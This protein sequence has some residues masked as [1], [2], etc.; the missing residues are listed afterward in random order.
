MNDHQHHERRK[1]G[2]KLGWATALT[3]LFFGGELGV[4]IYANSLALIGDA[5]HNVT[6]A[7]ALT[8]AMLVLRLERRPATHGKSFGYTRA[9]V[10]AA[11]VNAAMLLGIT[12]FLLIEA[13]DRFNNPQPV[14]SFWMLTAAGIALVLN[15]SMTLWLRQESKRD[16]NIRGAV[17]HLTADS[18]AS[19]GVIIGALLIRATG[20][21]VYDPAVSVV[22]GGLILL[23]SYGILRETVNL[24][25]E[26]TPSGIDPQAVTRD[27]AAQAAVLGV[28]HL[29]IWALGPSRPALSCHLMLGDVSLKSTGEVLARVSAMLSEKYQIA[30]TTIQFEHVDCAVD[31]PFCVPSER[32]LEEAMSGR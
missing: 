2:R 17:V 4:G 19:A 12:A 14:D 24:L 10:L 13:W 25:L 8:L 22:I 18:L 32:E 20:S 3:V 1:L 7:I 15:V 26:G 11:F 23:S 16:I 29:H 21:S 9:G 6:D 30:H 27:L 5:F 28:H 31:D